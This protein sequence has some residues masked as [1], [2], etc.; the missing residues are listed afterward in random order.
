VVQ[1]AATYK[2]GMEG[3]YRGMAKVLRYPADARRWGIEGKVY[4]E[5]IIDKE[6]HVQDARCLKGI[7]GGCDDEGVRTISQ[8]NKWTPA[9]VK[10]KPVIQK[11]VLPIAFKLG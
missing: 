9:K 1:E 6:G 7:G 4:I 3:L 8:M 10:G 5:F 2:G 11:M